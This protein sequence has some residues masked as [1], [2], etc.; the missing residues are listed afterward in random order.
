MRARI[1][2]V[3]AVAVSVAS[4]HFA[5]AQC[6]D[7]WRFLAPGFVSTRVTSDAGF[8]LGLSFVA[9]GA[10]LSAVWNDAGTTPTP[11]VAGQAF[12]SVNFP[13]SI[14]NFPNPVPLSTGGEAVFVA[15]ADGRVYRID[16][17]TGAVIWS[18]DLRRVTCSNDAILATPSVQLRNSS[19]SAFQSLFAEDL[20]FVVT[21]YGC[22]TTSDNEAFALGA[23]D[24]STKWEFHPSLAPYNLQMD[25]ASEGCTVDYANN[26]I[27]FGTFRDLTAPTT[28][29]SLWAVSTLDGSLVWARNAGSIQTQ[30]QLMG[31]TVYVAAANNL[32]R[33][34]PAGG[35]SLTPPIWTVTLAAS[36]A[37]SRT[38]WVEFRPP[39]RHWI[40]VTDGDGVAHAVREDTTLATAFKVWDF[41]PFPSSFTITTAP[42]V[43]ATTSKVYVGRSDGILEQLDASSSALDADRSLCSGT[44]TVA[45]LTLDAAPGPDF[46]HLS[47]PQGQNVVRT[48]IPWVSGSSQVLCPSVV[49]VPEPPNGSLLLLR[50]APNPFRSSTTIRLRLGSRGDVWLAIF[51]LGGRYVRTLLRGSLGTGESSVT[52]NGLSD[53]GQRVPSGLYFCRLE[54]ESGASSVVVAQEL[55][56]VR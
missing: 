26:R 6:A 22:A 46:D 38:P 11:H 39:F 35:G 52:W 43:D 28:S 12:W 55:I 50:T 9:A 5:H 34:Y 56:L 30:P 24:G 20:V 13:S 18:H 29:R 23:S 25:F 19:N 44:T 41:P 32:L 15:S 21:R 54:A 16:A 17:V 33:A 1:T 36:G 47:A 40:F 14:T 10:T 4:A 48:C 8:G 7:E 31:G 51:D 3:I 27:Y 2:C 37:L 49:S 53:A 45:D 42:V